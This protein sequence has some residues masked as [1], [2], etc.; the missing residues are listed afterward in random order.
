MRGVRL[1]GLL[2][3]LSPVSFHQPFLLRTTRGRGDRRETISASGLRASLSSMLHQYKQS[4]LN[5]NR[6]AF[7][8]QNERHPHARLQPSNTDLGC[9]RATMSRHANRAFPADEQCILGMHGEALVIKPLYTQNDSHNSHGP[10][11]LSCQ[12]LKLQT[13]SLQYPRL[14][15]PHEFFESEPLERRRANGEWSESLLI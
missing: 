7:Y 1:S 5:E 15:G 11:C 8:V 4:I 6:R 2:L 14:I 10:A 13:S 9:E 3:F 12:T